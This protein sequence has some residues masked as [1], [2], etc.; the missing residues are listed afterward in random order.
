[1]STNTMTPEKFAQTIVSIERNYGLRLDARSTWLRL[2]A[3]KKV[4]E[5]AGGKCNESTGWYGLKGGCKR[6][7]KGEGEARNKESKVDIANR[8]RERKKKEVITR[9]GA[10]IQ[11]NGS[12]ISYKVFRDDFKKAYQ[13][14]RS[15]QEM[16]GVVVIRADKLLKQFLTEKGI[17]EKDGQQAFETLKEKREILTVIERGQTLM[18]WVE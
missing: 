6:G 7:K 12:K 11:S 13:K 4:K 10:D 15:R 9:K 14:E 17:S 3:F 16:K 1:M 5:L 8:I 18:Q 2:D